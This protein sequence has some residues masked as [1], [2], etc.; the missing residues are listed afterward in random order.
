MLSSAQIKLI[1]ISPSFLNFQ[2]D[3]LL[4]LHFACPYK[5]LISEGIR[6]PYTQT[7]VLIKGRFLHTSISF[8]LC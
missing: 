1:V 7:L 5:N 3:L 6:V 4:P 8:L 2:A